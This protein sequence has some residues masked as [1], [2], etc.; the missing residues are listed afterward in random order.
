MRD[1]DIS[2]PAGYNKLVIF[3]YSRCTKPA[4]PSM[5][6]PPL[7]TLERSTETPEN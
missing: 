2:R 1:F 7:P 5:H 6:S 4:H 3:R